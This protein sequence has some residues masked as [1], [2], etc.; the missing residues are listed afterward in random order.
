MQKF[1]DDEFDKWIK[2]SLKEPDIK[3]D[4]IAWKQMEQKLNVLYMPLWSVWINNFS[5]II[6]SA[7]IIYILLFKV[8]YDFS[9]ERN[10]KA[11]LKR[12]RSNKEL[13]HAISQKNSDNP[14][15]SF[16]LFNKNTESE[17][18]FITRSKKSIETKVKRNQDKQQKDL[19]KIRGMN[20]EAKQDNKNEMNLKAI[21]PQNKKI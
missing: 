21:F 16:P 1:P 18:H 13:V 8:Q 17:K 7:I 5:L 11:E 2:N 19:Q 9:D 10:L 15:N 4:P 3:F 12:D 6:A 14:D 20:K